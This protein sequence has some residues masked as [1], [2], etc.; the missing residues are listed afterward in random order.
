M[1]TGCLHHGYLNNTYSVTGIRTERLNSFDPAPVSIGG[2]SVGFMSNDSGHGTDERS[3]SK[4]ANVTPKDGYI[5][6]H[7]TLG[8]GHT[9]G[10]GS[11]SAGATI[12]YKSTTD[13]TIIPSL[14]KSRGSTSVD[15]YFKRDLHLTDAQIMDIDHIYCWSSGYTG[16]SSGSWVSGSSYVYAVAVPWVVE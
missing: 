3:D 13:T 11:G 7:I 2:C 12:Y 14:S 16:C 15:Y 1:C 5:L 8:A 9:D 4:Y 6:S 10:C